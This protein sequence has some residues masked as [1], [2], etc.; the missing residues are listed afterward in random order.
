MKRTKTFSLAL[1]LFAITPFLSGCSQPTPVIAA[2]QHNTEKTQ[3]P[4]SEFSYQAY[5]DLLAKY[6]NENGE[7]DYKSLRENRDAL[8]KFNDAMANIPQETY[9]AWDNKA[10]LALWINAYNACTLTA[11]IDHYPIQ[12][13]SIIARVRFPQN[14]IRQI[15][16]IWDK[17]SWTV[18][19]KNYT[20]LEIETDILRKEFADEPR[21]H[22]A[23]VC[24]SVGCPPLRNEPFR[25]E[26]LEVQLTDQS[27][28]FLA[29]PDKLNIDRNENI[30]Y[31]S[32]IFS[33]F[34]DDFVGKYATDKFPDHNKIMR[35][36]LNFVSQ[37]VSEED[38]AYLKSQDYATDFQSYDWTLN[39]RN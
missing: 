7:V 35:A 22:M 37:Y 30:V 3:P 26:N 10:K 28:H 19:G 1:K 2:A 8:D 20:L 14:S 39:E 38:A 9:D 23:I 29:T 31:L 12:L 6:V 21:V 16:G 27:E 33:W 11:I 24:A 17:L 13:G 32:S 18:I 36:V 15:P 34:G 4:A 5:T 25:A